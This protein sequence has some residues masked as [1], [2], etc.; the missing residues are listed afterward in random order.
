MFLQLNFLKIIQ[1]I[2]AAYR[3]FFFFHI[4]SVIFFKKKNEND[5]R[6]LNA[7]SLNVYNTSKA[8]F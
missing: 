6:R 3:I 4:L 7:K 5:I 2:F 1:L 8:N